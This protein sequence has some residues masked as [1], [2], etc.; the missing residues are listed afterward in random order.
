MPH[1][2]GPHGQGS[3]VTPATR[4]VSDSHHA[5]VIPGWSLTGWSVSLTAQDCHLASRITIGGVREMGSMS[6]DPSEQRRFLLVD[7]GHGVGVTTSCN[8]LECRVFMKKT[9]SFEVGMET[10]LSGLSDRT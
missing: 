9:L 3:G 10:A 4:L 5:S 2:K 1:A 8:R 7:S 6:S